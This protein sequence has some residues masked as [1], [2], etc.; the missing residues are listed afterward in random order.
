MCAQNGVQT[1]STA[2]TAALLEY[3]SA[4]KD[5]YAPDAVFDCSLEAL[6]Q[7]CPS[8]LIPQ[9]RVCAS[10]AETLA[11]KL[12]SVD[13]RLRNDHAAARRY[14][15]FLYYSALTARALVAVLSCSQCVARS[16][17]HHL[18]LRSRVDE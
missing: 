4:S 13:F 14:T 12:G 1:R 7:A 3:T 6:I 8:S 15:A 5:A 11:R 17:S 10:A 16:C 9:V 18:C 2:V